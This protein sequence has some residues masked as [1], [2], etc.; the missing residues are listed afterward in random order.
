MSLRDALKKAAS[1]VVEF[2]PEEEAAPPSRSGSGSSTDKLWEELE[3]AARTTPAPGG[4]PAQAAETSRDAPAPMQPSPVP[5]TAPPRTVE[6]IVREAVGPNLDQIQVSGTELP[7]ITAPDGSTNFATLYQ[8]VGIPPASYTA[9]QML[10]ML[11]SLPAELPLETRRQTVNAMLKGMGK[12]IGASHETIVADASRK[13]AALA[14]YVDNVAHQ[15]GENIAQAEQQIAALEAQIAAQ[16]QRIEA[17]KAARER[18]TQIC[19][20]EA[21]RLNRVLEFFS[22]KAPASASLASPDPDASPPA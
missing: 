12:A 7:S 5:P 2:S 9:E 17:E 22:Q 18:G 19:T 4:A 10:E 21:G 8:Q 6:Q 13:L 1:L 16:R 3:Q 20:A 11:D 14:S 15:S